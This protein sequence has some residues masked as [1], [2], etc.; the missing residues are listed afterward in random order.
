MRVL[1]TNDDG[2]RGPGLRALVEARPPDAE[3]WVVAPDRERSA[4]G[5]AITIHKPLR[6][7]PVDMGAGVRAFHLNGTPSDCVKLG[8]EIMEGAPDAVL[9][10]INRGVNLGTDVMY[11]GTVA[12]A[13]EAAAHDYPAIALSLDA[14]DA[15]EVEEYKDA[16][17][18]SWYLAAELIRHGLPD[19]T[20]LNVNIPGT[21]PLKG[22]RVT[23]LGG[24]PWKDVLHERTDPRGRAYWWLA[25]ERAD[26]AQEDPSTDLASVGSGYVSVTPIQFDLTQYEAMDA[27][28]AWDLALKPRKGPSSA[29]PNPPPIG[30]D[31]QR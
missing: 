23:R 3:V 7:Q 17:A 25:G 14:D 26:V 27:V 21:G 28:R 9:S 31:G 18:I 15:E 5:R 10:G 4:T 1:I 16:A 22:M 24:R 8:L 30:K 12:G 19:G 6:L 20:L 29:G 2:I 11:S 13:I